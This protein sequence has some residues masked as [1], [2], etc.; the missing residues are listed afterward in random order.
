MQSLKVVFFLLAKDKLFN[1]VNSELEIQIPKNQHKIN[2][3]VDIIVSVL[4]MVYT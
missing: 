1:D 4:C 3:D 2:K